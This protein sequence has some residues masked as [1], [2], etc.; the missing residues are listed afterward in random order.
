MLLKVDEI[1][2][3]AFDTHKKEFLAQVIRAKSD[4]YDLYYMDGDSRDNVPSKE[5]RKLPK[6]QKDD[7][8]VGKKF[9]DNGLD[10]D[11][12]PTKFKRGEFTVL[13]KKCSRPSGYWCERATGG[14]TLNVER[15]IELFQYGYVDGLIQKYDQE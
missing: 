13:V 1:V 8:F 6:K 10:K 5:L 4:V 15:D 14:D 11:G 7:P 3:A 2:Y 9:F 12:K